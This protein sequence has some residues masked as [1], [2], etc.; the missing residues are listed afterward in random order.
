MVHAIAHILIGI[1]Y[2]ATLFDLD[3][4]VAVGFHAAIYLLIGLVDF[5]KHTKIAPVSRIIGMLG[6][7][8]AFQVV[9]VGLLAA[10]DTR[11]PIVWCAA[12]VPKPPRA[13]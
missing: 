8:A 12:V 13:G 6:L 1:F 7:I 4:T 2:V 9:E 3:K 10:G 5:A 11:P